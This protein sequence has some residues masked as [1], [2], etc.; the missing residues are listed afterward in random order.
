[1]VDVSGVKIKVRGGT[2]QHDAPT[3]CLTCKWANRVKGVTMG[4]EI[5]QCSYMD[6][7]I[8]FSVKECNVYVDSNHP[9]LVE[10]EDLAWILRTDP[11]KKIGFMP[12]K[13]KGE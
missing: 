7:I 11:R 5:T 12:P 1:M 10:M 4:E 13:E 2:A 9:T 3:L 8:R 6:K